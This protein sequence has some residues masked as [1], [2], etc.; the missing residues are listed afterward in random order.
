MQDDAPFSE[1]RPGALRKW[2][3]G[4]EGIVSNLLGRTSTLRAYRKITL[5]DLSQH[6]HDDTSLGAQENVPE[7]KQYRVCAAE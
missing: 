2:Q 3:S 7:C 4:L 5:T 1:E 6:C